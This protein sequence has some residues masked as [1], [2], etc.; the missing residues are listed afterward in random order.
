[1]TAVDIAT[2][3]RKPYRKP[4][5]SKSVSIDFET[6]SD[7][8]L[9]KIGASKYAQHPSTEVLMLAY[10]WHDSDEIKQWVPAEG[11]PMPDDLREAFDDP[12]V[13]IFAWN[14]PFE[15]AITKH[16]LK[17]DIP[18]ERWRDVMALAYSLSLPGKLEK[19]GQVIGLPDDKQKL[20]RGKRLITKFCKP[21]KPTKRLTHTRCD[22]HTDPEDWDDF[23]DYNVRDVEAEK[24]IYRR[25]KK[26]QMPDHEWQL[27]FLD[28]K[29]NEAGL[30][31]NLNAVRAAKR[32]AEVVTARDLKRLREITGLENPNSTQQFLP[33]LRSAGYPF[34]DLKRGHV[35]RAAKMVMQMEED[36]W[37][38]MLSIH[39]D[40]REVLELRL[41]VS[42]ASVKK[43]DALLAGT[44]EIGNGDRGVL[45]GCFQF[46]GAGRTWR[47]AARRFQ[48]HNLPRPEKYL[49]KI[50]PQLVRDVEDL[51]PD[52]IS[53]LYDNEM[54]VLTACVRPM[55]QA[56][57]GFTLADADLS[58]IENV[59]LG[60][61]ARDQ[62]ILDV[63]YNGRDPYI[64]FA[65][66]MFGKSYAAIEAICDAGDKSMRTTAKPGVL[67]CGYCLGPGEE[68]ENQRTGEIE[69]TGLLGYARAM[70]VDMTPELAKLSVDTF[71]NTFTGVTQ[72]WKDLDRAARR[73][74]TTGKPQRVGYLT[75][76]RS[77]PFMRII[78]PSGRALHY[79]RPKIVRR[80]APWGDMVDSISYE[81][82]ENGQ[83]R[84]ITTHK[85]KITENVVQAVAR[86]LLA[87]GMI[88]ADER[89]LDLRLHVH[90]Q[91][92]S[93]SAD[94]RADDDL[95]ILIDCLTTV[96]D[97]ADDKLPLKAA[98]FLSP[99]FIKD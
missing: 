86:D 15:M 41:R 74:I 76:D 87:H 34:E 75:F 8:D 29:I 98:G 97:W 68:R 40:L 93:L 18:I 31:I 49:E 83:W 35:E 80:R 13:V 19:A 71:R 94:E 51:D 14:A 20:A 6:Y 52:T 96:P 91:I 22:M 26:W 44:D 46:A 25:I 16:V 78:L 43:F 38:E 70:Y 30:P 47:W 17:I 4:K 60:W 55:V 3:P 95:A 2:R 24:A 39:P 92:V 79:L 67:G 11:E 66:Y 62:K 9:P 72:F 53:M 57:P 1:M 90:D 81:N 37:A 65:Q 59:V 5:P 84:R 42:K 99:V 27:W 12:E 23:K 48:A 88:L 73:C 77:G 85:G 69:A 28:Q 32:L 63:F 45:R 89:G 82:L 50:V 21:R 54:D 36:G 64:D 33:W 58:A 56:P 10:S 61:L 7:S